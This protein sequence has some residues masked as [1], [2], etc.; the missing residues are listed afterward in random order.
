MGNKEGK[1]EGKKNS[2]RRNS[3]KKLPTLKKIEALSVCKKD[4]FKSSLK[5]DIITTLCFS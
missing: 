4:L 5:T 3:E 1:K 2:W